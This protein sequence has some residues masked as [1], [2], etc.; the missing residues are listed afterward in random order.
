MI[1]SELERLKHLA[2]GHFETS[3]KLLYGS[4]CEP[5]DGLYSY[6]CNTASLSFSVSEKSFYTITCSAFLCTS[7]L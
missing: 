2:V 3:G 4:A 6:F 1:A 5:V 7:S